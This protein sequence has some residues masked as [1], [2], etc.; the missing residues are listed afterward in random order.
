MQAKPRIERAEP[1]SWFTDMKMPLTLMLQGEDLADAQVTIQQVVAGKVMKGQC[2]GLT[3][4]RQHN[5]ESPNYLFV[6]LD[7]KQSG[8]YRITLTKNKKSAHVDYVINQRRPDPAANMSY[9]PEDVIYLIMP[10]RFANG[11]PTNDN[12]DDTAEKLAPTEWFGR[13]G[14]DLKG[15]IDHLDAIKALGATAIWC[16]PLLLDNEPTQSY[17]G[18]AC[19]DYYHIDPRFGSN[20]LY[21]DYVNAAHRK[22]LKVIMDI[23][24][25]HCGSAHWWMKDL[26]YHDWIHQYPTFTRSNWQFTTAADIHASEAD[27]LG[28]NS[29][30][31]D[32]SMPDMNLDNPDLLKYFQQWAIWWIEAFDLDGLRVDTYP[33][34]EKVP[35]SQWTKAV[36]EEYPGINIV[37]ECWTRPSSQ[38]AYWQADARNPDGYNSNLPCVMDFPLQEAIAAALGG[39][40]EGW[41]QGLLKCYEVVADDY[42]YAHP[43]NLLIF[44]SNHDTPRVRDMLLDK[45]FERN[46]LVAALLATMRG[47]PQL[48][49]G[50]EFGLI[51]LNPDDIN[52]HGA[53]RVNHPWFNGTATGL[54]KEQ[55]D[56]CAYYTK[57]FNWR[58]TNKT[59][60]EGK[61]MH[62]LSRDNTYAYVRYTDKEAVL[63]Y[64]NAA[65]EQRQMP[66]AQYHELLINY[67][68]QGV[69]VIS[70][71]PFDLNQRITVEPLT[72]IILPLAKAE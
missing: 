22:G 35:I 40:G 71:K 5:A 11:D 50:E 56:L 60:H 6:D 58:R 53:L 63:V 37:G 39:T 2:L 17:H 54:Q 29:G 3:V 13:H 20:E 33:Y 30:W 64:I 4:K 15:I 36:R 48:T 51:S 52:N 46:K 68:K 70:G 49:Y 16:T 24:P 66:I 61:L 43:D 55:E 10:D 67:A 23:V 34:N 19:A 31:F 62:F 57:V 32:T 21:F 44:D 47:I 7:V 65:S 18:Y 41:G 12:T 28:M 27:F 59:V 14:G 72:A 1:L 26:P 69:D 42:L 9:G 45:S 8:T 25:N 38:I